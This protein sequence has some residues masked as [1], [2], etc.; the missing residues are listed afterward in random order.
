M[1]VFLCLISATEFCGL[2]LVD[3]GNFSKSM[4]SLDRQVT[5]WSRREPFTLIDKPTKF[6]G[7][8]RWETGDAPFCKYNVITRL[9]SDVTQWLWSTWLRS[10]LA[11]IGGHC[12][13][14]GADKALFLISRDHM[15]NESGDSM[16]EIPSP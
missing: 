9:N 4:W 11:K 7:H 2:A 6:D 8:L 3:T 12:P 1:W 13:S 16:D 15:I 14:E 5:W 10:H